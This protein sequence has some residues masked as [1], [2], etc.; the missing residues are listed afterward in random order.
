MTEYALLIG[1][2]FVETRQYGERPVNIPHKSVAWYPVTREVGETFDGVQDDAYI[3][4]RLPPVPA[5]ISDRQFFQQLAV[6][7]VISEAEALDAVKTGDLP[8][9]LMALVDQ[10]PD[11]QKF[12]A[13]MLLCG[14]TT[15]QR[16]YPLTEQLAQ[17]MGYSAREIDD[18]FRAAGQL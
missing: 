13:K 17:A 12:S 7:G 11:E 10:M 16:H 5:S 8:A 9:P 6:S 15:F 3:I 14:A 18:L 1:G 2:Q 4:R